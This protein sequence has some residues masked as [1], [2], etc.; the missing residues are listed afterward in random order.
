MLGLVTAGASGPKG[1]ISP[2]H[3]SLCWV[4]LLDGVSVVDGKDMLQLA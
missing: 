3:G 2:G 1:G 4:W